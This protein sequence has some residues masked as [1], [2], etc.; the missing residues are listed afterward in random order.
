MIIAG[1]LSHVAASRFREK[2]GGANDLPRSTDRKKAVYR[3]FSSV[4][5]PV[6]WRVSLSK[7]SQLFGFLWLSLLFSVMS[8]NDWFQNGCIRLSSHLS[9]T[10]LVC[11]TTSPMVCLADRSFFLKFF[12]ID[13][14]L[15][16]QIFLPAVFC[17]EKKKSVCLH[18]NFTI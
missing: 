2:F 10:P 11:P 9:S 4:D 3:Q 18:W 7:L 14:E 17:V 5:P 8:L 12:S 6:G 16:L 15:F 13:F 1:N